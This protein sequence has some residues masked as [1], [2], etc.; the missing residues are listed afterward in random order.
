MVKLIPREIKEANWPEA[1]ELN[2]EEQQNYGSAVAGFTSK[3]ARDILGKESTLFRILLLNKIGIRTGTIPELDLLWHN[4]PNFI[5]GHYCDSREVVLRSAEDPY[6]PNVQIAKDLAKL[7]EVH[8]LTTPLILKG[9]I[10]VET[11]DENYAQYCMRLDRGDN[12]EVIPAPDFSFKNDRRKLK[13]INPDYTIEWCEAEEEGTRTF[14]AKNGGVS[15]VCL[16]DSNVDSDWS[17]FDDSSSSG[18]V[19][20]V[21]AEGVV[22]KNLSNYMNRLKE[23][24]AAQIAEIEARYQKACNLMYGKK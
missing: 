4:T 2:N 13:A 12:F 9:L 10:P 19:V 24:K 6:K 7:A 18:R 21:D 22:P 15:W 11:D 5:K 16:R 20:V 17:D 8:T 3:T 23:Q 1:R 14:Y